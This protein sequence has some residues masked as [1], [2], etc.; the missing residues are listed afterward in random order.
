MIVFIR[1]SSPILMIYGGICIVMNNIS[2]IASL[3][4]SISVV[5]V[6]TVPHGS[7]CGVDVLG[8]YALGPRWV[9]G[10]MAND[11][12]DNYL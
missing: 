4:I 2:I 6:P 9:M 12:L 3:S 1:I 10:L 8:C 11:G 7:Q 5:V